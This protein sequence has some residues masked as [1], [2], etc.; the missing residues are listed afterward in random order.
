MTDIDATAMTDTHLTAAH[1]RACLALSK[2]L[3]AR[4]EDTPAERKAFQRWEALDREMAK[5]GLSRKL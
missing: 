4:G 2:A 1:S 5:R 3:D